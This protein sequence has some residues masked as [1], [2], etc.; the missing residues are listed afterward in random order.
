L[1]TAIVD[2]W[3]YIAQ[4]LIARNTILAQDANIEDSLLDEKNP[5]W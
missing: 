2:V 4:K 3:R 1:G 5:K